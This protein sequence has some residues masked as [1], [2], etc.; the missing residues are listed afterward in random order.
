M[1]HRIGLPFLTP[2]INTA[3]RDDCFLNFLND[4][5]G[6]IEHGL[7]F[8][9][10]MPR[11]DSKYPLTCLGKGVEIDM[12]HETDFQNA[13][14]KWDRRAKRIN[15]YNLLVVMYTERKEILEAFDELPYGKKVCFVPFESDCS[16]AY[17]IDPYTDP[18]KKFWM[19]IT[20]FAEGKYDFYNLFDMMLYGKKTPL[21]LRDSEL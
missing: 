1:S 5:R 10:E 21:V 8:I 13:K 11:N 12:I 16:S 6:C 3:W 19:F 4:P 2:L 9:R 7:E 18:E 20:G 17:Y 14:E 15:W